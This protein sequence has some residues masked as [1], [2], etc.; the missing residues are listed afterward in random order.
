MTYNIR[1]GV[2]M[3]RV[4]DLER[5]A[6]VIKAANP[7]IVILNEVDD[8]TARSFGI[9]QADSLGKLLNL[10]S[11]FSRSIDYDGGQYGNALLSKYP[12]IDFRIVD[13]STDSLLEGR[14]V[15]LSRID[16]SGDTIT[17]MGTHLGLSPEERH[18]QVQRIIDV[19]PDDDRLI[20]AGDFN[21]EPYTQNY[22][23]LVKYLRD[24]LK[25]L[26]QAPALTFPAD[27]PDR[28]I[29]YIFIGKSIEVVKSAGFYYPEIISA[30]DHQPQTLHF[31]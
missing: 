12:I 22:L 15:F 9:H 31:R 25:I 29:D 19:L 17:I 7:D 27:H 21:F 16:L 14:S 1:H 18:E 23:G 11:V 13:L 2:G 24:G 30:S 4:L 26:D 20:L 3:D 6:R 5:T 28:R 8:S 10:F